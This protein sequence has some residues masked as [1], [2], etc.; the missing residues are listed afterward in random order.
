[1]LRSIDWDQ[2]FGF[3][4]FGYKNIRRKADARA[5]PSHL[6]FGLKKGLVLPTSL[7]S[8]AQVDQLIAGI[9]AAY[10]ADP[11][12]DTL[13]TPFKMV[14][15]DLRTA[16]PVILERGSLSRSMRATMSLPGVF[17]PVELDGRVLVDGGA[18]NNVPADVVRA[19]G[20]K[21]VIAVNVGDLADQESINYSILG[22][23][24]ATID[25]MMRANTRKAMTSA[26]V[27][28]NVPLAGVRFARLAQERRADRSRLPGRRGDEGQPPALCRERCGL[29]AV[30]GPPGIGT[31]VDRGQPGLC[32]ARGRRLVRHP[33]HERVAGQARRQAPRH[34]L[35]RTRPGRT[36]GPGPLRNA[37]SWKLNAN[38]AGE[39]GLLVSAIE[40]P[41]APPFFMLGLSLENTTSDQFQR[42]HRRPLPS[43]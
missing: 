25:A 20:A 4:S 21:T 2:M 1:M 39:V 8:G 29:A 14:A 38:A 41:Y 31:Q 33:P 13:P 19:M 6:E 10:Y 30:A 17:P 26:D 18:M 7:N 11:T 36:L 27:V 42:E 43:V 28:L 5:Y 16:Q 34:R 22:L 15:V 12:F 32:H 40:K 35:A 24:G 37:F 23:A 3:T 9:T